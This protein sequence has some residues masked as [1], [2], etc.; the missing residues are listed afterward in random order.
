[1]EKYGY[2]D[3]EALYAALDATRVARRLSWRQVARQSGV[4]SSTL[5]RMAQGRRPDADGLAALTTWAGLSADDYVR[6]DNLP[7]KTEPIAA[8]STYLRADKNLTREGA[9]ALEAVIKVAY[10]D[11][12][13]RDQPDDT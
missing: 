1:M 13:T 10:R 3:G 6:S 2:F 8:I 11:L 9:I 12:T 4:S 7:P 5:T